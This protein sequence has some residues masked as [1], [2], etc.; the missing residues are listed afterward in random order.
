VRTAAAA[1]IADI[2]RRAAGTG[3]RVVLADGADPRAVQAAR[4]LVDEG[5]CDVVLLGGPFA[6]RE[7]ADAAGVP[8]DGI[9]LVAPSHSP[10]LDAYTEAYRA[11]QKSRGREVPLAEA[12]AALEQGSGFGAWLVAE[13]EADACVSGNL[14]TTA[15]TVRAALRAI[16]TAPGVGTVSSSFLMMGDRGTFTFA[17][18][19]VVPSPTPD[20][21]AD[22][23]IASARTHRSLTG[24]VPRIAMLSFSTKG[25]AEHELVDRVRQAT[26]RVRARESSLAVDGELQVDAAIVPEVAATKAPGSPV[27]GHA[28]VLV[29]PDLNS[30]NIGYK[31]AQRL[32]GMTALGPLLQG[33]AA[34]MHDL[35][36]GASTD[37]IVNVAAIACLQAADRRAAAGRR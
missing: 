36:R 14:S 9:E 21:L 6:L 19:G 13:G 30:G 17:D 35:S 27:A 8:L 15:D 22:I 32:G 7:A 23:A 3:M 25:S 20:Q 26:A 28:N 4:I 10:H 5:I 12:H 18:C 1:L 11:R 24:E 34:P 29:F 31:L 33:L 16:G 37:D 2:R